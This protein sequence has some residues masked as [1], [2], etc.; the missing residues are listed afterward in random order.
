MDI[1]DREWC[2]LFVWTV[3]GSSV[4]HIK[5]DREY[6]CVCFQALAEFWWSHVVPAKHALAG[7][8]PDLSAIFRYGLNV[9]SLKRLSMF[10][11]CRRLS[12]CLF[13]LAGN[14]PGQCQSCQANMQLFNHLSI[15]YCPL[16]DG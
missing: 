2:N 6:W 11:H 12:C 3:N 5:R 14:A 7:S 10:L 4:F 1:F 15:H 8:E 16:S 9:L 13:L